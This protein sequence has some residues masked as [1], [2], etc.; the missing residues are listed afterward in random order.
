[1]IKLTIT[2]KGGE[3]RA[4]SFDQ[5]EV[6]IGRVQGNDIVL[7]K[8][9]ISKRHSKLTLVDGRMTVADVKSTNGTYVN[10]RKISEPATVRPGDKIFVGDFLIVVDPGAATSEVSSTGSRRGPPPPPPARPRPGSAA[11]PVVASEAADP[12]ETTGGFGGMADR[13]PTTGHGRPPA[14]PPPPPPRRTVMTTAL[15]DDSVDIGSDEAP[16]SPAEIDPEAIADAGDL[17]SP[18]L[19]GFVGHGEDSQRVD[20]HGDV[21]NDV[22]GSRSADDED[23]ALIGDFSA[24]PSADLRATLDGRSDDDSP[25][26]PAPGSSARVAAM[27]SAMPFDGSAMVGA[28][29]EGLLADPS[30]TGVLIAA[31]GSIQVE[32]GAI[33]ESAGP[34]GDG[35]SI[36]ET[37]WQMAN[38]AV[39]PPPS[40]NPVVDVRLLDGTRVTALF[41]PISPGPVCAVIR[42]STLSELPLGD[43]A[44]G[45]DVERILV[46]AVQ[47]RRNLLVCGDAAALT[48]SLGALAGACPRNH[49]IVSVGAGIKSRPGWIELGPGNDPAA[50]VRAAVAFRADHLLVAEAGGTELPELLLAAA[51]GQQGVMASM[52]GRSAGEALTRLRAF[53]IGALGSAGFASLVEST[54]DLLVVVGST[55]AGSVRVLE[56]A[57][58][59]AE[60]EGLVPVFVARHS[61]HNRSS[62]TL[63]ISG[64]SSRL[65]SAI[66]AAADTDVLPAHLVRR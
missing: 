48:A 34:A 8:G 51:R 66:A 59:H 19:A 46:A 43:V 32:R 63:D 60:G 30:V 23:A 14:P 52:G 24:A 11:R 18:P 40:E 56:I 26:N 38:T 45:S 47:S 64:I 39:P 9:N 4:L 35:N 57:E 58:P 20:Q 22:F 53:S 3:P 12:D 16:P 21:G 17:G 15:Q 44:G 65:A 41:P 5:T 7:A 33:L 1:M 49:R 36:A 6:S 31:D 42:R 29:L 50:L 55:A 2:E 54:I 25:V 61:E 27:P 62:T 28:P 10:G 37:V 13:P